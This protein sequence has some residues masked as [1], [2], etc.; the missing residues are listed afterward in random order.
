MQ[1]LLTTLLAWILSACLSIIFGGLFGFLTSHYC[2]NNFLKKILGIYIFIVKGIPGYV[3]IL[4]FYYGIPS[5]FMINI[6]AFYAATFALT[7]CSSGYV[8]EII[9]AGFN[10]VD[11]GQWEASC[12]LGYS[13]RQAF[14]RIIIPQMLV[15]SMPA[16][17]GEIE[18]LLKSTSLL[19]TIGVMELTR[20]GF[21]IIS[22]ELT[23]GLVYF[24]IAAIYLLF[25]F[26]LKRV[27]LFLEKRISGGTNR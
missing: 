16:L 8:A 13:L 22:R 3:Q 21:N 26:I 4:I 23:P 9:R 7:I 14:Q 15:I 6:S 18:Q 1:G 20:A 25:S 27:G 5:L 12:V 24:F 2:K 11:Y 19:A 17:C 10:A